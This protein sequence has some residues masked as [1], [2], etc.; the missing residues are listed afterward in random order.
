MPN[1]GKVEKNGKKAKTIVRAL[2]SKDDGF[3]MLFNLHTSDLDFK[4]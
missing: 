1:V 2:G 3:W 4:F